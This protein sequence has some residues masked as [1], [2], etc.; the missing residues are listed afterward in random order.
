MI[1]MLNSE[2]YQTIRR[3][4]LSLVDRFEVD[5][6]EIGLVGWIPVVGGVFVHPLTRVA[7]P[8]LK[9]YAMSAEHVKIMEPRIL[10]SLSPVPVLGLQHPSQFCA[11]VAQKIGEALLDLGRVRSLVNA[12][13]ISADLE[14][15]ALYLRGAM[16]LH[17]LQVEIRTSRAG[18]LEVI[19][20]GTQNLTGTIRL[21][22]RMFGITGNGP[23]DLDTLSSLVQ[24]LQDQIRNFADKTLTSAALSKETSEGT[25]ASD[26]GSDVMELTETIDEE[27]PHIEAEEAI[28]PV[29]KQSTDDSSATIKIKNLFD[30]LGKDSEVS[31]H[32]GQLRLM[33]PLRVVQGLYT[34]FLEQRERCLFAGVLVTP[35]GIRHKV[36]VDLAAITDIKDV[37]DRVILGKP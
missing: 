16:D 20:I 32:N 9:I 24:N 4:L 35:S 3:T 21:N 12:M 15:N 36:E 26:G 29:K 8:A 11:V 28:P 34:F 1:P 18:Q 17:G 37:F 6:P 31:A 22:D 23:S 33:V 13:G 7:I 27:K 2:S 14:H 5:D 25:P 10:S 30:V 19:S